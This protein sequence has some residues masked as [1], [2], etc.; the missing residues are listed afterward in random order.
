M[1]T[2]TELVPTG[3]LTCT[4]A[5]AEAYRLALKKLPEQA[6]GRLAKARLLAEGGQV[7]ETDGREWE[8]MSQSTP[9]LL[10]HVN[11][12]CDWDCKNY[13][14]EE[15]CTHTLAVML[16][17]KSLRLMHPAPQV[18]TA[19]T[20]APNRAESALVPEAPAACPE[21]AFSATLKGTID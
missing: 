4:A 14:K 17:K 3:K 5:L 10:H 16:I 1:S 11:G 9:G 19:P 6:H 21:A 7:F 12:S 2:V 13:N 8:V 15:Y 18:D 20:P